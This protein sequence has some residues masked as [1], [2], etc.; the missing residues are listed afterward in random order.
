MLDILSITIPIYIAIALGYG[1][2]RWG[3]F[4]KTEMRSFGTFV[5]KVAMPALLFNALSERSFSDI[6]NSEYLASY[7]L[8]SLLTLSLSIAW[9]LKVMKQTRGMSA[10]F[11]LGMTCPNSGFVGYPIIL[12]SLGPIAG[13]SL[14]LNMIVENL[15]IIPLLLAWAE[16]GGGNRRWHEILLQTLKGM[17][18]NPMIWGII[19]GFVFSWL[20]LQLPSSL[21]R[22]VS[23]FAQASGALSLFVIGGSLVALPVRGMASNVAQ[24][25]VGKLLLHPLIMLAV[26][27]WLIPV[28][29]PVLRTAVVLTC[30]MPIMGIYPILTQKHSHD[31]LSAAALL[32]TTMASFI[33]LNVLL[34]SLKSHGL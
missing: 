29:D 23:L 1:L 30:A 28:S 18:K 24:I 15:L 17:L 32:V 27:T 5:V 4:T 19:L 7:A 2:T 16:T 22:T 14:A 12:L 13:V 21:S 8:A 11:A 26:L 6:L 33:T 34:W 25:T 31:G 3:L 10:C 20:G 9:T